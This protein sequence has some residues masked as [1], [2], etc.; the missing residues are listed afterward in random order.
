MAMAAGLAACTKEL[1]EPGKPVDSIEEVKGAKVIASGFSIN[2]NASDLQT[3]IAIQNGHANWTEGD[4]AGVAWFSDGKL[5]A[6]QTLVKLSSVKT[7]VSA[8]HKLEWD[9]R[10]KSNSNVFEG[11]HIAYRPYVPMTKPADI[12][13]ITVNPVLADNLN[14][15]KQYELD[16]FENAP[17]FSGAHMVTE[18]FVEDGLINIDMDMA[19]V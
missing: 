1:V 13:G 5:T 17:Y 12:T 14:E 10:F 3:K 2:P 8:N 15:G 4:V 18:E 16:R 6:D 7:Y 11:W 9:G 19:F